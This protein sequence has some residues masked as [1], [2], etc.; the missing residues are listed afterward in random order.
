MK[1]NNR[2]TV[3]F[4]EELQTSSDPLRELVDKYLEKAWHDGYDAGLEDADEQ[5]LMLQLP[6]ATVG[7]KDNELG[8]T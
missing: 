1:D 4:M 8:Q 5:Q 2:L 6:K 7:G 3:K